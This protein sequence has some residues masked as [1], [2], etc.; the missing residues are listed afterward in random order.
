MLYVLANL[1]LDQ[2]TC[3]LELVCIKTLL[4]II[5]KLMLMSGLKKQGVT[6]LEMQDT[7][8]LKQIVL[9]V[10]R[11]IQLICQFTIKEEAQ[12][13]ES[14]ETIESR[15]AEVKLRKDRYK[16]MIKGNKADNVKKQ[17][18]DDAD[19]TNEDKKLLQSLQATFQ[20]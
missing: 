17:D 19:D 5:F 20:N 4:E 1:N 2:L 8:L 18:E 3:T 7:V 10:L 11:Y 6:I 9:K 15:I 16:L 12:R 14:I 13:G